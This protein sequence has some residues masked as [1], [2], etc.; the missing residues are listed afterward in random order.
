[1][2][3]HSPAALA[4]IAASEAAD[5]GKWADLVL[6]GHTHGGQI[7]LPGL[8]AKSPSAYGEKYLTGW[9]RDNGHLMLVSNGVGC[10]YVNLRAGAPPQA[11]LLVF[12]SGKA[13]EEP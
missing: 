11:H 1:V 2:L 5:G 13:Q 6:A 3:S 9:V 12:R 7:R 10:S 8:P 4:S